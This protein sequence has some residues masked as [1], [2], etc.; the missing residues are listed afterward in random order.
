MELVQTR[1][2]DIRCMDTDVINHKLHVVTLFT[3]LAD[4]VET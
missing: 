2:K 1:G 3:A 4:P